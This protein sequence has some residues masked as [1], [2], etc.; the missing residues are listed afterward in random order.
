MGATTEAT[1]M[2]IPQAMRAMTS[3]SK[4]GGMVEPSPDKINR[5]AAPMSGLS[6]HPV[7]ETGNCRS[8]DA[9]NQRRTGEPPLRQFG[10]A[11]LNLD[12]FDH[13]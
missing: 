10:Q 1:P 6:P 12:L 3:I 5:M 13:A 11:I 2:P 9:A 7:S 8:T 4:F